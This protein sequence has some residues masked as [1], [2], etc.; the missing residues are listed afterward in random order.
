MKRRCTICSAAMSMRGRPSQDG[1]YYCSAELCRRLRDQERERKRRAKEKAKYAPK[2]FESCAYC[3]CALPELTRG[4]R[5]ADGKRVC[6][7]DACRS[8]RHRELY[9]RRKNAPKAPTDTQ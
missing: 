1:R 4:R 3:G 9:Y 2:G 6:P 7:A 8:E 5:A